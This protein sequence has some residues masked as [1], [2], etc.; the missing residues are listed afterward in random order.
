M[1]LTPA[2]KK[3]LAEL[4]AK[5]G[6]KIPGDRSAWEAA[7]HGLSQGVTLGTGAS[8][9]AAIQAGIGI[10]P[11]A[12]GGGG[13]PLKEYP[14]LLDM[15]RDENLAEEEAL[16]K[17]HPLAYGA[18]EAASYAVP[19][20]GSG[21]V[22]KAGSKLVPAAA[23]TAPMLT[24]MGLS[25]AKMGTGMAATGLGEHITTAD[26]WG[27]LY[28][29]EKLKELGLETAIAGGLGGAGPVAGKY[30]APVGKFIESKAIAPVASYFSKTPYRAIKEYVKDPKLVQEFGKEELAIGEALA[31]KLQ[32]MRTSAGYEAA[33]PEY[34]QAMSE[35]KNIP[36]VPPFQFREELNKL[37]SEGP[38]NPSQ[39]N[40]YKMLQKW[41]DTYLPKY[42]QK[43]GEIVDPETGIVMDKM[44]L[45]G[46]K[47]EA[48]K[49]AIQE[50]AEYGMTDVPQYDKMVGTLGNK[51]REDIG[52]VAPLMGAPNYVPLMAKVS[53]KMKVRE[54]IQEALGRKVAKWPQKAEALVRRARTQ[55]EN[56]AAME[57]GDPSAEMKMLQN[58]DT[59]FSSSYPKGQVPFAEQARAAYVG[60]L[61][62]GKSP[63]LMPNWHTG[64]IAGP[65]AAAMTTGGAAA[66][67]ISPQ[68]WESLIRAGYAAPQTIPAA[69]AE[70]LPDYLLRQK[71]N[72]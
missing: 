31:K 69:T 28:D 44:Q 53:E 57:W 33:V 64:G 17:E 72:E 35:V 6:E 38:A 56:P 45:P 54:P 41:Q 29:P 67:L 32:D 12:I 16:Q 50:E 23:K 63:G 18:G 60:R 1:A 37:L 58:F 47:A 26:E 11:E 10:A 68:V 19:L 22:F 30:L 39:E 40:A 27:D 9:T 14:K 36:H 71:E 25:A 4:R 13:R 59:Q 66:P 42:M 49:R 21:A 52:A 62:E 8:G 5:A 48:M 7:G 34:K 2:E 43:T 46:P 55:A 51:L 15:F 61:L 65:L 24:K 20:S 3:E 70:Y